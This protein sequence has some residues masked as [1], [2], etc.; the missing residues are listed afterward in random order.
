MPKFP[1][2]VL[3]TPARNEA[4]FIELTIKSVISQTV[5]PLRWV[6]V[7]DGSSDGTDA[8]VSRYAADHTW[9]E[10][11]RIPEH[12]ERDFAAKVH[13]FNAGY[14]RLKDLEY[15]VIGN[16]DG[17]VS[18]DGDYFCFLLGKLAEDASARAGG[19]TI[20][21]QLDS[22]LRLPLRRHRACFRFLPTVPAQV[23]RRDRRLCAG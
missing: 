6:I 23:F 18:F 9:I 8:I 17:D 11:V 10:L 22:N 1:V 14:A 15:E 2:Y 16:L 20:Q 7:S 5:R 21:G 12:H 3:V 4:Q 19:N 13:A